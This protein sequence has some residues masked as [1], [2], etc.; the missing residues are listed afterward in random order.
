[1]RCLSSLFGAGSQGAVLESTQENSNAPTP[2]PRGS[3]N[4]MLQSQAG[5]SNYSPGSGAL[6]EGRVLPSPLLIYTGL[7][8]TPRACVQ[9]E[10]R[11]HSKLPAV[12]SYGAE[13]PSTT[14]RAPTLQDRQKYY[15]TKWII[16]K[17]CI[18][19]TISS[20]PPR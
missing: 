9:T 17:T 5:S 4:V 11:A 15:R 12:R 2:V 7:S 8:F 19:L 1:M 6:R 14:L 18:C 10:G 3:Q 13:V 16:L 20:Q